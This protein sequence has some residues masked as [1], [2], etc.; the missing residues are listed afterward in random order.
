MASDTQLLRDL[1]DDRRDGIYGRRCEKCSKDYRT[2][3]PESKLCGDCDDTPIP[4]SMVDRV[5]RFKY[6][7]SLFEG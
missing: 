5:R 1:A 7:Q 6:V 4:P 3:N 2:F